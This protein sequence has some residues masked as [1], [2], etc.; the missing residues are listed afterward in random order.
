MQGIT[1]AIDPR[2]GVFIGGGITLSLS[3]IHIKTMTNN[4]LT[5]TQLK[6]CAGG[7]YLP[8]AYII[9]KEGAKAL[10]FVNDTKDNVSE[11]KPL[12]AA[13]VAAGYSSGILED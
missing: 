2:D 7:W 5:L 13:I 10:Q 6:A 8:A 1:Q 11:G 9:A 12:G 4:E 3:L